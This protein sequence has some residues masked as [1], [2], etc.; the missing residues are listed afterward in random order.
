MKTFKIIG[1][2]LLGIMLCINFNS[3]S[4]NDEDN[5]TP[6]NN[7]L[8]TN[9]KKLIQMKKVSTNDYDTN[10]TN[11]VY[12]LQNKLI[13]ISEI[14][15][16]DSNYP[17]TLNRN[18]TWGANII[19]SR[20][21]SSADQFIYNIDNN[22]VKE[23]LY[24]T[25]NKNSFTYNPKKQLIKIQ[26]SYY[27]KEI[28]L[29]WENDKIINFNELRLENGYITNYECSYYDQTCKG[30][31]PLYIYL[32]NLYI[33]NEIFF[34]NPELIGM[35]S[36]YLPKQIIS[37]ENYYDN[38]EYIYEYTYTFDKEGYIESCTKE[39]KRK[40]LINN[41]EQTEFLTIYTFT[42]E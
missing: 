16:A 37:K 19:I 20:S 4:N 21:K 11:F 27:E 36:P 2:T 9:Q 26:D 17:D 28:N 32:L 34:A 5:I 8:V 7:G 29:T 18:Y 23:Y 6:N 39:T 15:Y 3:C 35:R 40:D 1:M 14:R 10:I 30:Y 12:D 38:I 42:W 33:G 24:E 41:T 13:S 25:S 31:F 22:L